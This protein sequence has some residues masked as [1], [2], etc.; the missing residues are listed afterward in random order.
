MV[1]RASL[2]E[3]YRRRPYQFAAILGAGGMAILL[4]W[5]SQIVTIF[6]QGGLFLDVDALTMIGIAL[7]AALMG[8]T[9]PL[10]WYAWRRSRVV[11]PAS[12]MGLVGTLFSVGSLSC[13]APLLLPGVL[14]LLGFSGTTLLAFNLRLHQLRLPLTAVALA[15]LLV[16]LW[17]G[18][19]NVTRS[20]RIPA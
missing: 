10:H 18:L 12:G 1:A 2:V 20:C 13:C 5:S 4:V 15:F 17:I 16:S 8:L 6:P 11:A 9:L 14:S 3:V 19:R 7:A